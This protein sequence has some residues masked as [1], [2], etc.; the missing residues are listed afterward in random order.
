[1]RISHLSGP[2]N[3]VQRRLPP[4]YIKSLVP[5]GNFLTAPMAVVLAFGNSK[6]MNAEQSCTYTVD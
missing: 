3:V 5:P 2:S 1:M 6:V 4:F